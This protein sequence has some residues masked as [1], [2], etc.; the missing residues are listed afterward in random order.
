MR[1]YTVGQPEAVVMLV[2]KLRPHAEDSHAARRL[3]KAIRRAEARY[4]QVGAPNDRGFYHG[5]ITGYAVAMKVLQ[6]KLGG[7][8]AA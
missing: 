7:S 3:S 8:R 2:T 1:R 5:L 6:G 4:H